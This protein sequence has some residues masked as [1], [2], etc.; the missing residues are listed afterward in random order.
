MR[1]KGPRV[2]VIIPTYN[3]AGYLRESVRSALNQTYGNTEV[4]VVD[5]GSTDSTREV[6]E[7][8]IESGRIRYLYQKNSGK[9]SVARNLGLRHA[10][11]E[12]IC[13][14]DSDDIRME[15]SIAREVD[16]L[17]RYEEVGMICSDWL[18]FKRILS[19]GRA[20]ERSWMTSTKYLDKLPGEFIKLSSDDFVI[21]GKNFIYEIFGTN[22]VFTSSVIIR[23]DLLD[24]AGHFDETLKIGEDCDLWLRAGEIKHL[25]YITDPLVYRRTHSR[26]I[27]RYL[28]RNITDDTKVLEKFMGRRREMP[29]VV[30]ERFHRR[31]ESFYFNSGYFFFMKK[32]LHES[33]KRFFRAVRYNPASYRNYRYLL[34]SLFPLKV[35]LFAKG[36][37]RMVR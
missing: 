17:D 3:R 24:K 1:K 11:G 6:L 25:A 29:D 33:R 19:A 30:R 22:F 5:D 16:I 34:L 12:Y 2:S 35:V 9:P 27:T 10:S 28:E 21:F 26:N 13:F 18:F 31:L 8:H 7:P 36:L 14:L 23:R 32:N 15:E 37:K 20:M 4:I